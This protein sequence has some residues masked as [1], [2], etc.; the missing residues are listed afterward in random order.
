MAGMLR[1][2]SARV[3]AR[4]RESVDNMES[5]MD[6]RA[7]QG[8][9][10]ATGKMFFLH[11][12]L[13]MKI[14][15]AK[16]LP[17]LD[18]SWFM[19]SK[20]VSDP[21]VTVDICKGGERICRIAKTSII[22]D[23]LDPHWRE[24][25][26]IDLCHQA[27]SFLF[28]VKDSDLI[29]VDCI[30][31]MSIRSEDLIPETVVSG[32]FPL[33]ST[34]G[35]PAGAINI[36]M[37]YQS[38][39]SIVISNEVPHTVFPMRSN[40]MMKLYQDA[41]TPAKPPIVSVLRD[42]GEHYNPPQLW[43]DLASHIEDAKKLIY[44]AGWSFKVDISLERDCVHETL[45]EL[46]KKKAKEGVRVLLL[47][48]NELASTDVYTTGIMGTHDEET[49]AYFR[50]SEVDVVLSARSKKNAKLFEC[51]FVST[52]YSHHQKS[53]VLDVEADGR[54]EKRR[55]VAYIGG[56]DLADG[57]WDTPDH[58]LFKT[59]LVEHAND[60][61]N[62]NFCTTVTVG[63]RQPWHDIHAFVDGPTAL[64]I[65][66]NFVERWHC[67]ATDRKDR[68]LPLS[69]EYFEL[70]Y[71][72]K[73]NGW[74]CQLFRSINSDSACFSTQCQYR[75]QR[76]KGKMYENSI[77]TAYIHHV[78]RARRFI[79]IENQYFLGSSYGWL[80]NE[81]KCAHLIPMEIA[82]RIVNGIK[83]NEDFRVY[84][85]VPIHPEG[86]PSSDVV[87]EI[88]YWQY[89]TIEM[90]Y[91]KI[92]VA[93]KEK[94]SSAHPTDYLSL[95]CLGKEESPDEVPESL[96]F[97]EEGTP[98]EKV[99]SRLRFMIYVHSKMA[100]MDD[101]YII[102]GSANIN[103]RSMNG[104]RDTEM[105]IGA[106]ETAH[107][108]ENS[109]GELIQGSVHTFRRAL[110]AEH[111]GELKKEHMDP[112]KLECMLSMRAI[113]E[114]NLIHYLGG[115]PEHRDSHLLLYPIN[116]DKNGVVGVREDCQTFPDTPAPVLGA[117][118]A[119]LPNSLTT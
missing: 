113:G 99:R 77:Q 54:D 116:V 19:N 92:A 9:V 87:Q 71:T 58:Y 2:M 74:N 27:E 96:E 79:F 53:V 93:L 85:I 11:G 60:F 66:T 45:G 90:M 20:N 26:R 41:H 100:I 40:C 5:S 81:A 37:H 33:L 56:L 73:S 119:I 69:P 13:T 31:Y 94:G 98:A 34:E 97:P 106:F 118:S 44:I 17:N 57:R 67:E 91:Q 65:H 21:Y 38:V 30:G 42:D 46:L 103:E 1:R 102:I 59:L 110:W 68:L 63:P 25:F 104:N 111:C 50:D 43:K 35:D 55:L 39:T 86:D 114:E 72:S 3:A 62:G 47:V 112:S 6:R 117:M 15:E 7:D 107:T 8:I 101:E 10:T 89:R 12:V 24:D 108:K 52:F 16:G 48:W 109:E 84:I 78:R 23:C 75:L 18:F 88:L 36:S 105:A 61:Y 14:L 95:F 32:W 4:V 29:N 28:S 83:N 22:D 49:K 51:L 70:D 76:K 115:M 64:D 82:T 80:V